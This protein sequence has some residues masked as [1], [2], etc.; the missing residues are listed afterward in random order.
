MTCSTR[1]PYT[2]VCTFLTQFLIVRTFRRAARVSSGH[3]C[4]LSLAEGLEGR[5]GDTKNEIFI[6]ASGWLLLK[7]HTSP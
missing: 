4:W 6:L 3:S 1:G 5:K 7:A 2:S